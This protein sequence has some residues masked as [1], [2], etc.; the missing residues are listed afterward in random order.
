VVAS[1]V[2]LTPCQAGEGELLKGARRLGDGVFLHVLSSRRN[3]SPRSNS[4]VKD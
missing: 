2:A 4:D 1:K 3:L